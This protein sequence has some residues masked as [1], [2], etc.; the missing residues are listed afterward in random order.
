VSP[1]VRFASIVMLLSAGCAA[2]LKEP[3][4]ISA[5]QH[6]AIG[7]TSANA[8]LQEASEEYEKRPDAAAVRRAEG[9][10]LKAAQA[11]EAG[12]DGLVCSI[13]AK[14]WL[15]EREK[16]ASARTDLAVSAVQAGQWC[17][18][19]DP[20]SPACKFWLGVALGL[21]ARDRPVTAEDG[22]KRM[23]QLLRDVVKDAPLLDEAGPERVL[24]LLLARAPGW[25]IGPGDVEEALVLA[26]KAVELRP[27]YPPNQVA[28]GEAL[29][30]NDDRAKALEALARAIDLAGRGT[31][32]SD[33][34]APSWIASAR[35]LQQR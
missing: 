7:T 10:C 15:A 29:L 1:T 16:D 8:L 31:F 22:L 17:L 26:R 5:L 18:R 33:P 20:G 3:P 27:D 28:L 32:A 13:R 34:D 21:Q 23:A 11:D 9:L 25:P 6:D 14:A 2:A 12:T 4:P 30:K 19:R 35:A 24:S